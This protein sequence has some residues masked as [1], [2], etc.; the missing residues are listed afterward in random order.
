MP[1]QIDKL[2]ISSP[3][4]EPEKHWRYIRDTREFELAEGRRSAG[5]IQATPGSKSFDDPGIFVPIP[6]VNLIRARV[7]SW[8]ERGYP[9]KTGITKRLLEHWNDASQRE[10]P[11]FFCQLEAIETLIWLIEAPA[12]ERTGI[13]IPGDGGDFVRWCSKMA[14]GS[15]KTIIMAMIIAWQTLNKVANRQDARFS[16]N[17]LVVAPGLTVKN[18]LAVLNPTGENNFYEQFNIVPDGMMEQLREARVLIHNWQ[19]LAWDSEERIAKRKSVDKRG[20]KSD[21]A[22]VREVLGEMS[23]AENIIVINDEAHHAWRV[24]PDLKLKREYKEQVAEA[25]VW[26]GGLDRIHKARGILRTFDLSATPFVPSG[27]RTEEEA[28]FGWIVSDFGLND[29][30][31]SGLVK[32]PRVGIRD[33]GKMD[34]QLRPRL[35]HIYA[36]PE[37]HDDLNS[38]AEETQPLPDLIQNAYYLLGKDWLATKELWEHSDPPA[39]TPP[40]MITVANRTET[41]AR[42]KYSFDH[43]E[44]LIKELCDPSRTLHIDSKVLAQAEAES[45]SAQNTNGE[46]DT[47]SGE[48]EQSERKLSKKDRAQLLRRTVDTIGKKGEPGEQIVNVISVGML[49]EGWDA[50][51]V[52]HIM[53]LR[54]FTSQLL[55]EQVVG[56]GLRR[57][58]YEMDGELY[59]P[60][61]VNI[62]GVPFTFL[63][64]EGG[65][66]AE[67]PT[68]TKARTDI[69]P[70]SAN[71]QH[72]IKWPNIDRIDHIYRT[73]LSIDMNVVETLELD[74]YGTITHADLAPIIE[75]KPLIAPVIS[76]KP[77][78]TLSD[79]DL[80]DFAEKYRMQT[81]IFEVTKRIY[82][83]EK[84]KWK[85]T[86][87]A[88]LVQLFRIVN[89]F[90]SSGKIAIRNDL[91]SRDR[92]RKRVLIMLNMNRV[93]LHIWK[94]IRDANTEDL[95]P[96]FNKEH[97]VR[98]TANMLPWS[99]SRPA[100]PAEKTH[101]NFVVL[102]STW[103][104]S[105]AYEL[106]RSEFVESFVKNDHLGFVVYYS[107]LGAVRRYFP[108]FIIRLK[109]G[110]HLVLEVKGEKTDESIEKHSA[111]KEWIEAVNNHGGFGKWAADVSYYP[112]DLEGKLREHGV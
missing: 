22:Y 5:Y 97:P 9:G 54:A 28:L 11:F 23:R 8:R 103:E 65:V 69:K 26:V 58:S 75:G 29:A 109:N 83:A 80:S 47:E 82:N 91:F 68:P 105:E 53:G 93:V 112:S 66:S 27:K 101:I 38:P 62:F 59:E 84:P 79:I 98:S 32:T 76:G 52:T 96:I 100:V 110:T 72:E 49:T 41:A 85:G 74:P 25:T 73:V 35:Y 6:L 55:C 43:E 67:R 63:P 17:F 21:E 34:A 3:F 24:R 94:H 19:F 4:R 39:A 102:D 42:I 90:I 18:R 95:T 77:F 46:T 33:D 70:V 36:D 106:D 56:R 86:P 71:I 57:T 92:I 45:E 7:K 44:I 16:K 14:T 48:D 13:E 10:Y 99:T 107:Y 87:E 12:S 89:E 64:H 61:Y 50:R 51:T 81:I 40:V 15:G 88:L 31:E 30:I 108:D 104:A 1:K 111:L 20:A 2:I 37:V 78:N 60:E